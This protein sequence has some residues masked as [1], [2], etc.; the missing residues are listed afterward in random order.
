MMDSQATTEACDRRSWDA[1]VIG[2]GPAGAMAARELAVRGAE[3]LLVERRGFPREKVCGGCLNGHALAVLRSAGLG[4][5]A[6]R[7][8]GVPLQS[9]RLGV[10]GRSVQLDLPAGLA[11]SRARFDQELVAA[12]VD[13]GVQFLPGTEAQ[14][15]TVEGAKRHVHLGRGNDPRTIAASLVLVAT[16]LGPPHL[17][18]GSAPRTRVARASK[19]GTGC[20]LDAGSTHYDAGTI[21]MAVG[22]TGYVGL[23]RLGDGRLHVAGAVRPAVLHDA[24][25]PGAAA[26]VILAEA[27]FAP[28]PGLGAALWRGTPGLTRRTRPLADE[29]LLIL[30]DAAGYVEP[31][32]GE[33]I[34]WALATARAIGPLAARGIEHWEPPL[35]REW[36][37]LHGRVVRRRQVLCRAAA[38]ILR[39]PW[40]TRAA[41]EIISRLPVSVG[42]LL[43]HLNA[44]PPFVEAS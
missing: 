16:G 5:L 8:G 18:E 14:V 44:A 9:F 33:G 36:E 42:R 19:V 21:H 28:V 26:A 20:F 41:F 22:R 1:I 43:D 3:V 10:R 15:G 40:L 29:R 25:G 37:V 2:A 39:R 30:G 24:G 7:S 38:G 6:E 12:A 4:S 23:V 35:A 27:G 13:A 34:A 31:F 32:T 17:P 11:V